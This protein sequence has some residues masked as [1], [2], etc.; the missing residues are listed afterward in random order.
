MQAL[1][2]QLSFSKDS[3][4]GISCGGQ[5][6]MCNLIICRW[7]Q[8]SSHVPSFL[9]EYFRASCSEGSGR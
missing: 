3:V 2:S 1:E 8:K 7:N 4:E 6:E 5:G 9:C